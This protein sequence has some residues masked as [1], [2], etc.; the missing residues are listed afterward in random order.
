MK[1]QRI[2]STVLLLLLG[3]ALVPMFV[4]GSLASNL[5]ANEGISSVLA[6]VQVALATLIPS[7]ALWQTIKKLL[8]VGAIFLLPPT[9]ISII[10]IVG[11]VPLGFL[12]MMPIVFWYYTAYKYWRLLSIYEHQLKN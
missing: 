2:I 1:V 11:M 7:L 5:G 9:I 12:V 6:V 3:S 8:I 10:L 4:Y